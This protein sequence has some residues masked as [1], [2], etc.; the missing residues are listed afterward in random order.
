MLGRKKYR[1]GK[2]YTYMVGGSFNSNLNNPSH[3]DKYFLATNT[4][5]VTRSMDAFGMMNEIMYH[6]KN[7]LGVSQATELIPNLYHVESN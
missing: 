1:A 4:L 5:L 2:K 3:K 6:V 7:G